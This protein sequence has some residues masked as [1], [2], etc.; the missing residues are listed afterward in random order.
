MIGV[1]KESNHGFIGIREKFGSRYLFTEYHWDSLY[2]PTVKPLEIVGIVP[3]EI[4][5][6]EIL[7]TACCA[8]KSE[9]KFDKPKSEGGK[10]W[11]HLA[12][13]DCECIDPVSVKNDILFCYLDG[14]YRVLIE[15]NQLEWEWEK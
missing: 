6:E 10:G 3:D 12:D 13:T 7:G 15:H 2:F 1:Y 14:L 11:I 8:C 4:I 9:V 5:L